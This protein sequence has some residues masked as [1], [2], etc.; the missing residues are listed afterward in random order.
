MKMRI[1]R[2][3]TKEDQSPYAEIEFRLTTSE[4]R[5]PDGSVVF[6]AEDV[7]VPVA[8]SQVAA[9][10]L[11]QKYFRKAGVPSRL[12]KVEEEGVPA[13]LWRSIADE[14]AL[15][16]LPEKERMGGETSSKQV[17]DRLA[18]TWTYWGWKGSYFDSEPDARAFYDELRYMLAMQMAAPNSPQWFNTGLFWAYG[19]DGPSQGHYYVDFQSGRQMKSKSA[20]E[21]PQPHACFIQSIADDLVNEGGIMDLWVR[22]AR[23]FKYGSGTGSNFSRLRGEGEKLSGGGKSSGLMSFLKI[24]DRAA[25]AIKSGGTTRR[26]AKMVVVDIDHPDIEQYIDWKAIEE[27][28]VAN[29]VSGSKINQRHL[30][31]ILKACVNCQ[32]SGDDCF[33][34][35]KNPVLR[36]EIKAA[37]KNAVP[38]NY[39]RRVVQF[40]K[41]GYTDIEFPTYDTDWDSDAYLTVSGQNSNNS[42]R[43]TDE[44][45]KAVEADGD[46]DLTWRTKP[47]KIAQTVKAQHLWE[48][49]GVA[50]WASADPGL[51]FHTT[52]NDWHTCP[53]SGPIRASNPCSE[54]MFLDDTACNLASLNLLSFRSPSTRV[55][56]IDGFEH[57][58]RLWTIVLEISVLMAQ[59][60]SKQIAQLSYEFRTLGL[61]YANI[62]GLLMSS[63]IAYDS[64]AGRAICGALSAVMTGIAYAT[65][66]EM[67]EQ[68]Q[69]F[70][71][72]KKNREHM[73]RV[74]RNHRRAAHGEKLG[75]EK[76]S[77]PPTPLDHSACADRRLI[78]HAVRAWDRA[79]SLGEAH[80]YRNA[81]VS[82]I[83][84]T[85][86]IGLVMDC[87]TTGIE[88]DFALVKFKK[89]AG[90]GYFKII[91]RA[92][93]E[94]LRVLGYSDAEI[95]KI[96]AFAVGHGRL[97]DAPGINH[98]TLATK[99]FTAEAIQ[100]LE[101]ALPTAFDIKFVFNKWTLGEEFCR[102]TLGIPAETLGLASFDLL[103]HLGFSKR[104][105]EAANIHVCG[106]M[107]VEGAPHLKPEHYPVFDCANPCGRTGKRYL[108]V[109]SHIRMM[110]A[111]QPF[112][113][114]AI[115]KTINMPNEA[116]VED[117]KAAYLL[118]WKLALKA[119]A[120]YRDGSKLSQPLSAQLIADEDEDEEIEAFYEKPLAART[121]GLT[122]KIVEKVVERITVIR[123]RER[124]PDRR[125]GYTQKAVVGGHKV[126]LRT[127]EYEDGRLGEI[128]I[129]MHKEGAALRSLL[130]NFAI[131]ISL[132]LQ[133]GVPLEEYVDAFTFTRF[134]PSGPVQGN[135][136]IKY[137]TSI[138]DYV[139]RELAVSYLSRFDLAHVDPSDVGSGYDALGRGVEEGKPSPSAAKYV[140]RGLTRSRTDKLVVMAGGAGGGEPR[141]T[142]ADARGASPNVTAFAAGG[143]TGRGV[144]VPPALKAGSAD[145]RPAGLFD[146][147]AG[148]NARA[149]AAEKRA[150]ARAKGY[151]GE[152]CGECGNFTLVRNGTC[153]KCDTCGSTS[154]CS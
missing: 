24:G 82:V 139:F 56:D 89:L 27:Q 21:H 74:I 80:G 49:I 6:R 114:G 45:L 59:F 120:L 69:P 66:A 30:K 134:E 78:A 77:T 135:D 34:P 102:D 83:A 5:N 142:A 145:A 109:E 42:V 130:N 1:A 60:P 137:A 100:R 94:A 86:T 4:I 43:V 90:G 7:E 131:A 55:F 112:I 146:Q 61:G 110:A 36:R 19:I 88:P 140:S 54:Y 97:T 9:D 16:A 79:L 25:G 37:R 105:I 122:E 17:F 22:E 123:E 154:G 103:N 32:G 104:E 18:G 76:L 39:I 151:E 11:A 65:S 71:G 116:S 35:D 126:Y 150:E 95:A 20:Y 117:C 12:Q 2:R 118:S 124:M 87:D 14:D 144:T 62:G 70:P 46:W 23:L 72:Y 106:A 101:K 85:G 115:S 119:N 96:E 128:F 147:L 53:A 58:V 99:G 132:G 127:G 41:Q 92:V 48:K 57:A 40:A 63:G 148:P 133:Y 91:N 93:P 29:L 64:D 75:Y 84:P 31:A 51:Q 152:A 125:K 73:L 3:Y 81:Q 107:T 10:V 15:L 129:D 44:F 52:I 138:L 38:D 141:G 13:F 136:S 33:D 68:L 67:A 113:S 121:S 26:A 153:M 98:T 108:S 28:K 47:G 143:P 149:A 111:A 50:A 8:W